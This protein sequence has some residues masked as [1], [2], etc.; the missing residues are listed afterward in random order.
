MIVGLLPA[1]GSGLGEVARTGQVARLVEGYLRPYAEAFDGL[2][3]F[4]Y[5]P[6]SL[7]SFTDD[8]WLRARVRVLAPPRP[9]RRA[10][11][12]LA[13]PWTH[14]ADLRACAVLRVF[15][16][17]GVIPALVA[18]ARFGV[19]YV[20]TYGF[21]YADLS[22]GGATRLAKRVVERVG[23]RCAAA[24]I[25]T[26]EALAARAARVARRVEVI[27]NGVD[28]RRFAPPADGARRAAGPWR[29]LYVGRL[30]EEKNLGAL[31][32]AA[33]RL[34]GRVPLRLTLV[35][36]GPLEG[37]L[38][39]AAAAA[40]VEAEFPGVIDQ[41]ALPALYASADAFV[42]PSFTEGHP[43]V[44]LEAMSAGV[45]VAAS[46]CD[47]NASLVRDGETGLLF[48]ARRPEELADRLERILT[49]AALARALART[50]RDLVVA[51]YDLAALVAREIALLRRVAAA[52]ARGAS[53]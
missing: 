22:R 31:I 14:A 9:Q 23:L 19:P 29:V 17:T 52:G 38:R 42:L 41:R 7:A 3:Y 35:G 49:D 27:P 24:V 36:G 53:V 10:R 32:H 45:P 13:I 21:W 44:L 8:A 50:G 51:R 4:S 34:R 12:A 33:G 1:L 20:T 43:K 47:G 15:Q 40:G 39:A 6:E 18:R 11:R 5:L 16:I 46:A 2:A 30:S 48:D 25:A 26:T 28:C 37:E